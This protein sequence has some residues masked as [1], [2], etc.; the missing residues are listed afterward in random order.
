MMR[1]KQY[2]NRESLIH[3][4][5][6]RLHTR[7][8][9][10]FTILS[11][12]SLTFG[13]LISL[14]ASISFSRDEVTKDQRHMA[15]TIGAML[16]AEWHDIIGDM[17]AGT[18][19]LGQTPPDAQASVLITL[20]Q[21]CTVCQTVWLV[22]ESG[23]IEQRV[24]TP[25]HDT[26]ID[27][28][29][30][31]AIASG[32]EII[33]TSP[34][35][36][37]PSSSVLLV[38]PIRVSDKPHGAVL[39]LIDL[40]KLGSQI[41]RVIQLQ[42][43]GYSY[44]IDQYGRLLSSPHAAITPANRDLKNIRLVK[45]A[46]N[47]ESWEPPHSQAYEGLLAPL[48]DGVWYRVPD[49]GWYILVEAPLSISS[50]Y[51]W[52][53]FTV[54]ITLLLL[55][56]VAALVLGRRV[57]AT[58]TKPLEQLHCGVVRLRSGHWNQPLE[59]RRQ[60]E[61]GQLAV[62]FNGMAQD[63]Q[64]KHLSLQARTE[65]LVLANRDQ[66]QALEA[67]R[68][69]NLLKT[70]FVATISHELRTPLTAILGFTDMLEMGLYGALRD[71]HHGII[72]RIGENG[73]HLLQLINDLLD[74]S[75]LEAGKLELYENYLNFADLIVSVQNTCE[76]LARAKMLTLHTH[77][78]PEFPAMIYGD[79]LRLRQI[80][81]NL[82]SNAVKFTSEGT[83]TLRIYHEQKTTPDVQFS[84]P[85]RAF[86]SAAAN[87]YLVIEVTDTGIGI[88]PGDQISIF[89]PFRQVDGKYARRHGGTGLGLAITQRLV[90]LMHGTM[91]VVSSP[92]QG[93]RFTVTMPLRTDTYA[94]IVDEAHIW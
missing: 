93:S 28:Q 68:N 59:V 39:V 4:A 51:N 80:L 87:D 88:A 79:P 66:E 56:G 41:L 34:P 1:L 7:I 21:A 65:E 86:M 92:G 26:P 94:S 71:E 61:I 85:Q 57:A 38:F 44:I 32:R 58:I 10:V 54:Q 62:A 69:A 9:N 30:R 11:L 77:I 18:V 37:S 47:G 75:K 73:R 2:V 25:A 70:Q 40:Q 67:A 91:S 64:I 22:D 33:P 55:T 74:F 31:A 5:P 13:T 36:N 78:D 17:R 52:Y 6:E 82:V 43:G 15:A 90:T 50:A 3:S 42:D 46:L 81:L 53:L 60:D 12:A 89:E 16:A 76:P 29:V 27:A 23:Q 63:L 48:V 49:L 14:V 35:V 45:A 24:G 20:H 19:L 8:V 84:A 72:I 83:V